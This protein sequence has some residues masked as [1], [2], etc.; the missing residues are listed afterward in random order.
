V[1]NASDRCPG[2][3]VG[4]AVGP[5]GCS[6][7]Q[8]VALAFTTIDGMGLSK[9]SSKSL[10]DAVLKVDPARSDACSKLADYQKVIASEVKK[11][12]LTLTQALQL[13]GIASSIGTALNC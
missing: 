5:N 9:N 10:K 2:T 13:Q 8:G 6:A 12:N 7:I 3:L 11:G 4:Q 1:I